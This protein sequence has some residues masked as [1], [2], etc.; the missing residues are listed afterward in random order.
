M[1]IKILGINGSPRKGNSEFLLTEALSYTDNISN[2]KIKKKFYSFR[3]KEFKPC[4]ACGY[5]GRNNGDCVHND[6]FEDLKKL[7]MSSDIIIFCACLS[8]EYAGT[9]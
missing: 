8:Y 9:G 6:D 7:W 4:I 3:G 2:F 5:C 1:E